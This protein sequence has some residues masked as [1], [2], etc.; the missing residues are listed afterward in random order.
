MEGR[1]NP[2]VKSTATSFSIKGGARNQRR[3]GRQQK[4][5]GM[6]AK[7]FDILKSVF[8]IRYLIVGSSKTEGGEKP[9]GA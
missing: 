9:R 2:E 6:G 3:V 8:E 7:N 1:G 5:V 4:A